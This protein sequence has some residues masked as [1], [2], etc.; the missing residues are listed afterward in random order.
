MEM[1]NEA[2]REDSSLQTISV[3]KNQHKY[4]PKS[5]P[6]KQPTNKKMGGGGGGGG[7]RL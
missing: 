1:K 2:E 3:V 6:R 5:T 7:G 4:V